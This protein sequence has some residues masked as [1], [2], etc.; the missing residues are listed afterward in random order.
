VGIDAGELCPLGERV[1]D[2]RHLGAAPGMRPVVVRRSS[3]RPVSP[4]RS[5]G[6]MLRP[7]L[8]MGSSRRGVT[9][10]TG[11]RR[12]PWWLGAVTSEVVSSRRCVE[13][14]SA[15]GVFAMPAWSALPVES[16]SSPRAS[17]ARIAAVFRHSCHCQASAIRLGCRVP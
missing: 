17:G 16:P 3:P 7:W 15:G 6:A 10:R 8:A 9:F 11:L 2:R 5:A 14:C 12:S 4:R 1:A 13:R